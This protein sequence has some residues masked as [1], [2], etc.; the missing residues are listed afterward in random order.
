MM[1]WRTANRRLYR[2]S[3]L[4]DGFAYELTLLTVLSLLMRMLV[5]QVSIKQP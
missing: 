4:Q 2:W 5:E 3:V 1:N